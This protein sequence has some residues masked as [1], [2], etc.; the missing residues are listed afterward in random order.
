MPEDD[1]VN[2]SLLAGVFPNFVSGRRISYNADSVVVL[3]RTPIVIGRAVSRLVCRAAAGRRPVIVLEDM[4]WFDRQSIHMLEVFIE[5][6]SLPATIFITSRPEKSG[7]ITRTL[8]RLKEAGRM[9][10]IHLPLK[11][12]DRSET[13]SFCS[14]FLDKELLESRD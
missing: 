3:E 2:F 6:L 10:F 7:Y 9:N 14:H 4:H 5:N 11:P 1:G 12:F 13:A 8:T